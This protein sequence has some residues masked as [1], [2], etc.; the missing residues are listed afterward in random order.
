M[1]L[2]LD[3]DLDLIFEVDRPEGKA[4]REVGREVKVWGGGIPKALAVILTTNTY[5]IHRINYIHIFDNNLL[6]LP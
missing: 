1:D 5:L 4:V 2:D 3:L 6:P